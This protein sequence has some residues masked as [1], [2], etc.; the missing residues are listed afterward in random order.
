MMLAAITVACGNAQEEETLKAPPELH[1]LEVELSVANEV[2]LD[3]D[4]EISTVVTYGD[5]KV[6]NADEVVYEVWEEG[7]K[8]DST[9][10]ESKNEGEGVYTASTSFKQDGRYHIQVHVTAEDQHAMP[11]EEVT[12]GDGGNYDDVA[13]NDFQTEGFMMHFMKPTVIEKEEETSLLLHLD[14]DEEPLK[15]AQVRYEISYKDDKKHDWVDTKE[16]ADGE[17][18]GSYI[19]AKSGDYTVTIHVENDEGLHEHEDHL[20][21]VK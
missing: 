18:S 8:S 20:I 4:I 3:E 13:E 2:D 10:I 12:V 9:M 1:I 14:I 21:E 6:D 17:Y 15:D 16:I 7:K 5:R 11:V 19:F